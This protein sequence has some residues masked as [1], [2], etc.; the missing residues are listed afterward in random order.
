MASGHC[1]VAP[2]AATMIEYIANGN[3]G[4]L[5]VPNRIRPLDFADARAI[6]AR[7]RE[8]IERGHERWLTGI[9]TLLDFLA[10]PTAKLRDARQ[11]IPVRNRFA[12]EPIP[13]SADN[14]L[15][16]VVTVCRNAGNVLEA[17]MQSVLGQTGCNLEYLVLDRQSADH[18]VDIIRR[19]AD[20]LAFWQSTRNDEPFAAMNLAP[21]LACGEWV[22][23]LN[24]GDRFTS[25]DTLRRMFARVPV[26]ADMVYGHS[27]DRL[28]DGT[29]TLRHAAEFETT[30]SRLQRGDVW[31]DWLAGLPHQ[32]STAVRRELL[33]RLQFD[34]RYRTV[35]DHDLLF[36]ARAQGAQFFNCDEVLAIRSAGTLSPPQSSLSRKEWL[37]LAQTH[38]NPV[39]ADRLYALL[40]AGNAALGAPSQIKR[41]GRIALQLI[42]VLDRHSPA[43]ARAVERIA[44]NPAARSVAR[45]LLRRS[46]RTTVAP[47]AEP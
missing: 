32:G 45:R 27:L 22:L 23:F 2:D 13:T 12:A 17:T 16:S 41:V 44:M 25:E 3:N 24:A 21:N 43:V 11:S 7:A 47:T 10:T 20:R 1:V 9:P 38:A 29:D 28:E 31:F 18:S 4:L 36:R 8:S 30:W 15:V 5:Y 6:G 14:P 35:A 42:E 19:Y 37:A 26:D 34:T 33:M 39:A 40:E 46:A